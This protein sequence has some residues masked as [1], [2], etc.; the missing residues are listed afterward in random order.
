MNFL[1]SL[2]RGIG[3]FVASWAKL[4]SN[5]SLLV[6]TV[7]ITM[8]KFMLA[9]MII[10]KLS[11]RLIFRPTIHDGVLIIGPFQEG[12][13]ESV[14]VVSIIDVISVIKILFIIITTVMMLRIIDMIFKFAICLYAGGVASVHYESFA[15]HLFEGIKRA[16][17]LFMIMIINGIVGMLVGII[18]GKQNGQDYSPIMMVRE[19]SARVFEF[20]WGLSTYLSIPLMAIKRESALGSIRSSVKLMSSTFGHSLGGTAV[21]SALQTIPTSLFILG[22]IFFVC[23]FVHVPLNN[24][25]FL[26]ISI[27]WLAAFHLIC[28]T[29][30]HIIIA[31]EYI[32]RTG[33]LMHTTGDTQGLRH[34]GISGP[35]IDLAM[36][37]EQ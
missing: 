1:S 7:A 17:G 28:S 6:W 36:T 15:F 14:H 26:H 2:K 31:A 35:A 10:I 12:T 32:F 37:K 9:T 19:Y 11:S 8:I 25:L 30:R 24:Q 5:T 4:A 13:S 27:F 23:D 33:V 29:I 21:F 20:G 3:I 34:L 16:P 22:L 18:R